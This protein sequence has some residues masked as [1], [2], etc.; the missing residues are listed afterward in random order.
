MTR[1][2]HRWRQWNRQWK[3]IFGRTLRLDLFQVLQ[4]QLSYAFKLVSPCGTPP[5]QPVHWLRCFH[6]AVF[7]I[8]HPLHSLLL[9]WVLLLAVGI[10]DLLHA[11]G[12][13]RGR[14]TNQLTSIPQD[15]VQACDNSTSNKT[16]LVSF[17]E[18]FFMSWDYQHVLRNKQPP[19]RWHAVHFHCRHNSTWRQSRKSK[20]LSQ[21]D[22]KQ[23][24]TVA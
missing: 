5:I 22:Q 8:L 24:A 18:E 17:G 20:V 21:T 23:T 6:T 4:S 10:V 9:H 16:Q 2:A 15:P 13:F 7:H 19:W 11:S 14:H 3:G 12:E 1:C